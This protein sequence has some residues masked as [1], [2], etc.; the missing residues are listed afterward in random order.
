M[1]TK[2]QPTCAGNYGWRETPESD[3]VF[4]IIYN[5]RGTGVQGGEW[6]GPFQMPWACYCGDQARCREMPCGLCPIRAA[7]AA[8][9]AAQPQPA[10]DC[11]RLRAALEKIASFCV[12]SDARKIAREALG[13]AL[14][15]FS[16]VPQYYPVIP[17][18]PLPKEPPSRSVPSD[19]ALEAASCGK[20]GCVRDIGHGGDCWFPD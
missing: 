3:P 19:E 1:W 4:V 13:E 20:G 9:D 5:T 11:E 10:C 14:T 16:S 2:T 12:L 6:Y 8:F 15:P 18:D 17:A 7:L